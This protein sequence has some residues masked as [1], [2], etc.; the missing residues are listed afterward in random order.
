[1]S[2]IR[3]LHVLPNSYFIDQLIFNM[4]RHDKRQK[5]DLLNE[6]RRRGHKVS[7][8]WMCDDKELEQTQSREAESKRAQRTSARLRLNERIVSVDTGAKAKIAVGFLCPSYFFFVSGVWR[9]QLI[10]DS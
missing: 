2:N 9:Q 8:H 6:T 4:G 5:V 1:M 10:P 7:T 3:H